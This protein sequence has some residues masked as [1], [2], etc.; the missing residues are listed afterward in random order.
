MAKTK[1]NAIPKLPYGEG[2]ISLRADGSYVYKKNIDKKPVFVYGKSVQEVMRKMKA[3][4]KELS[5]KQIEDIK[6]TLSDAMHE[7]LKKHKANKLKSSS[8]DRLEC[9]IKNQIDTSDIA[10]IR[11]Q[12]ITSDNIDEFINELINKEYSWSTIKKVYDALNDFY[13]HMADRKKIADNPMILVEMP[14]KENVKKKVKAIE[15]FTEED[16]VKFINEASKLMKHRNRPKYAL[17]FGFI[18]MIFTGI[19]AGEAIALRWGDIDFENKTVMINKSIERVINREYDESNPELMKKKGI[20]KYI[21]KEDTTK[22]KATRLLALNKHAYE[23]ITQMYKYAKFK[24]PTG[25]VFATETGVCNNISNMTRS[26]NA[27]QEKAEMSVQNSGLHVLRHTNASLLFKKNLPIEII[28]SLLGHSV[29][30]CRETYLHFV[31][32]QKAEAIQKL[33]AYNFEININ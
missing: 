28:A 12:L 21:D 1:E 18:F 29:E 15:F 20:T 10:H 33:D 22:T 13:G 8:Y 26:L 30:V 32:E 2:S 11:W 25:F 19:R 16:I 5:E 7:W 4:E 6:E 24:E 9:T 31:Q 27:I 14:T 3:K 23:A 17:G